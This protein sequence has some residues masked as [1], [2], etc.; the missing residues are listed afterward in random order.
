MIKTKLILVDGISGSGKSTTAHYIYR[1][2]KKNGIKVK[3]IYEQE[4]DHPISEIDKNKDES[5]E[6]H[7]KRVLVEYPKKWND[8]VNKIKDDEYIYIVESF[9]FQDVLYFPHFLNDLDRNV[10]KEYSHK[11]INAAKHLDPVIVHLYQKDAKSSMRRNWQR[12]G[13][14]WKGWVVK[15]D[16]D[17]LYCKNRKLEGDEGSLQIWQD[18]TDFSVELFKEYKFNKIQIENL[19]QDW[20]V[21]RKKI[22]EFLGLRKHEEK[23]FEPDFKQFYGEYVGFGQIF[24][25]HE[26]DNRL[27]IDVFWKNLKLLPVSKNE[28]EMEGFPI[29]FKFYNYRGKK[30]LKLIKA[31]CYYKSGSIAEE[32]KPYN[33]SRKKLENFSAVYWCEADKLERRLYVKDGKFYYWREKGNE[34]LLIP[35]S[36]TKFMMNVMVDNLLEFKKVKGEW[37]FTFDVYEKKPTHSLFVRKKK[38][39][40]KKL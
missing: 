19:E 27:C 17:S 31:D 40:E 28:L 10:I 24:K 32:Y 16:T 15:S 29:S 3:W 12:R 34:S 2:I 8:F 14:D 21:Y 5:D 35:L 37:Q 30:K 13:D 6:D 23:L 7:S 26:K 11:L 4:K 18:F 39:N 9:L 20:D 38:K 25:L 1:Q 36:D 33:I 22:V